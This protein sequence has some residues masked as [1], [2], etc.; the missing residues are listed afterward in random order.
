MVGAAERPIGAGGLAYAKCLM[1]VGHSPFPG[2]VEI[3]ARLDSLIL[4]RCLAAALL[5]QITLD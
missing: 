2:R 1:I 4:R 3:A 5:D